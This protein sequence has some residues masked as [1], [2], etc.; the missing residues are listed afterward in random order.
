MS[1]QNDLKS[2]QEDLR[3][4]ATLVGD[5]LSQFTKLFQ[6]EVDLAKAEMG[7]K[8]SKVSGAIVYL[9]AAVVLVVPALVMALFALS[10]AVTA[11]GWSE[12]TSHLIAAVVAVAIAGVSFAVGLKRLDIRNLA[13]PGDRWPVAK[14]QGYGQRHGTMTSN[15]TSFVESLRTAARENPLAAGLIASGALWLLIGNDRLKSAVGEAAA[16]ASST[17]DQGT[18]TWQTYSPRLKTTSA[19][20][21]APE[22]DH[23][24]HSGAEETSRQSRSAV[25]E[26][27][28]GAAEAVSEVAGSLK[29]GFDKGVAYAHENFSRMGNPLPNRHTLERARSSLSDVLEQQPLVLGAIGL[30]IGAAIAGAFQATEIENDWLGEASETVKEDLSA[31]AK[32]VAER[33][34]EGLDNHPKSNTSAAGSGSTGPTTDTGKDALVTLVRGDR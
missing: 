34:G 7:E 15:Q 9:G 25:S 16:T 22:M 2:S 13:P 23:V 19:P 1:L 30:A 32:A 26:A 5:A 3:T 12:P 4:V 11:A 21:T 24:W 33:M 31:R 6:N 8:L 27:T 18:R 14:G 29:E 28:S 20:P 17:I 10:A